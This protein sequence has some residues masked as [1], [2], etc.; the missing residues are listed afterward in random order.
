MEIEVTNVKDIFVV[1]VNGFMDASTSP[2]VEKE[3]LKLIDEGKT[4]L[5]LNLKDVSYM[6]SSGLRVF[7][8]A[9]KSIKGVQGKFIVCEAND[10]VQEILKISGFDLIIEVQ[11]KYEEAI[12]SF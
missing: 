12:L 11:D 8:A 4:K 3:V 7:L 5:L 9:S 10:V 1:H 2:I 6:S